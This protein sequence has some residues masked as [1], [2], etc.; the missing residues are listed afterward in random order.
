MKH[1][2]HKLAAAMTVGASMLMGADANA[3]TNLNTVTGNIA[4]SAKGLPN[5]IS[6]VAYIGGA[7]LG[8]SGVMKLK[9]HVENPGQNPMKNA[10]VRLGAGGG[11]LA[12]PFVTTAMQGSI[13]DG[14]T[15]SV[16]TSDTV[17]D[18]NFSD[19]QN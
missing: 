17:F 19:F 16:T 4:E 8:V 14:D 1:I 15:S 5:M 3:A 7:G 13:S 6:M 11:L 9:D 18:N 2:A 10:L 12:V